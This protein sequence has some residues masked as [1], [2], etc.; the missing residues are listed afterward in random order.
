MDNRSYT[1]ERVTSES[2]EYIAPLNLLMKQLNPSLKEFTEENLLN[3]VQD[4]NVYLY[5][6]RDIH[7]NIVGTLT[8]ITYQVPSGK[9]G[10]IEDVVVDEKERGKGLGKLLMHEAIN[11]AQELGIETIGLTSRAERTAANSLYQSLG[12]QK[13]ETNVYKLILRS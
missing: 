9:R 11:K 12:F 2:S 13:R 1:I 10:Y 6:A 4:N 3:I 8:L 7:Q 5:I